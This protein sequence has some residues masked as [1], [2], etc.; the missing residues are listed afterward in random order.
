ME[1]GKNCE[2]SAVCY[3]HHR[4]AKETRGLAIGWEV[5]IRVHPHMQH[6]FGLENQES[7]NR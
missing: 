5:K 7:K 4:N 6:T 1:F 2:K 3:R